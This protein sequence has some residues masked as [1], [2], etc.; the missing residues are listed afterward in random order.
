ME[1][2]T[3]DTDDALHRQKA[4]TMQLE[5][6]EFDRMVREEYV[7][8]IEIA[9]GLHDP[10]EDWEGFRDTL[11]GYLLGVFGLPIGHDDS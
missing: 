7:Y 4:H 11:F 10:A 5:G 1:R 9:R 2:A 8:A 6:P 3:P